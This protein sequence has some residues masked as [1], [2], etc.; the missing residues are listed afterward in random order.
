MSV[1]IESQ[2]VCGRVAVLVPLLEAVLQPVL[3][4]EPRDLAQGAVSHH[5]EHILRLA[6]GALLPALPVLLF[7]VQRVPPPPSVQTVIIVLEGGCKSV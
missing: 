5:V 6:G 3:T 7:A 4:D 1:T 2:P